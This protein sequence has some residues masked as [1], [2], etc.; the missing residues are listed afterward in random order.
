MNK[1]QRDG[2]A[3]PATGLMIYQTNATPGFYYYDGSA[4]R[5]V[6]TATTGDANTSL[7][8]LTATTI[9]TSLL[10]D[11]TDK[12]NLG[13]LQTNWK[14][15]FLSNALFL[16]GARFLYNGNNN[17]FVGDSAGL[18][19]TSGYDNAATG[20]NS[21]YKNTTGA[22]NEANGFEA[23]YNNTTG[24]NNAANG[25]GALAAN[26]TG[27]NNTANGERALYFNSVGNYNTANGNY[28]LFF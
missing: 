27:S 9:N 10:P 21:M 2:I 12:R 15:L 19:N 26:T 18:N 20:V 13:N 14:G 6:S 25:E 23:L 11:N 8:N 24:S 7:S 4:W 28:A 1:S 3:T 22:F 17:A 5:P 16:R